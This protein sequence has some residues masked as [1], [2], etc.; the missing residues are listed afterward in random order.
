MGA[1]DAFAAI[2]HKEEPLEPYSHL[3]I[4]GP[5]EFL[6]Q[7]RSRD[8]LAG[9]VR[10]CAEQQIPLRVLGE[11]CNVLVHDDGVR[12]AVVRLSEP[13]FKQ[14]R[15]N[16]RRVEAG[17]GASL[18]A[19]IGEAGKNG[20]AGLETLVGLHGTVGGTLRTNAGDRMGEVS[21]FVRRVEVLDGRGAL[22]VRD[23]DDMQF[24]FHMS[25]LDD[26]V[27]VAAEFELDAD[28]PAAIVKRMRKTWILRKASQPFS[29]QP[30]VRMFRDPRGQSAAALIEQAGVS[31]SRFGG[32]EVSDRDANCVV[33]SQGATAKDVLRLIEQIRERVQDRFDVELELE[34]SV[35]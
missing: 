31:R 28:S 5:A 10:A 16:G 8:E 14:V 6:V 1:L 20:L 19:L 13:A 33:V 2:V 12:G 29:F 23:R 26:P 7:P 34:I 17:A 11:G 30:S 25:N 3:R 24:G 27:L 35:W 4:G 22:Q 32:A 21:Q 9:V 15:V 18:E